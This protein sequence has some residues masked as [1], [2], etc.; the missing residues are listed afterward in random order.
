[1]QHL[2]SHASED[3]QPIPYSLTIVRVG[4]QQRQV[5]QQPGVLH[6]MPGDVAVGQAGRLGGADVWHRVGACGGRPRLK[7]VVIHLVVI[8]VATSVQVDAPHLQAQ[9]GALLQATR[10]PMTGLRLCD[11]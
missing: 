7:T 4:Q 1:M 11:C 8:K 10:K 2:C 3:M 9:G 6:L 5:A